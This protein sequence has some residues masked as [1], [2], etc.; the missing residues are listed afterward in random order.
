MENLDFTSSSRHAWK[1]IKKLDPGNQTVS[2]APPIDADMVA[3]E[4]KA[5]G[6]HVLDHQFERNI[7]KQEGK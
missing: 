2:T 5:R 3:K 4:I 1:T 6:Q 7:Q